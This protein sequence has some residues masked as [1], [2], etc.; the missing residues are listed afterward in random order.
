MRYTAKFSRDA[1]NFGELVGYDT[2][3]LQ[4]SDHLKQPGKPKLPAKTIRIALPAGM[5]V[6]DV[7][8]V[9]AQPVKLAGTYKVYPAQPPRPV[10]DPG[11]EN[12]FVA[13]DS[14][15]YASPEAYPG[16]LAEFIHQ[17]D[18][19]GQG[20]ALVRLY[21]VQYVP[22]EQE[23]TL[24]TS[25]TLLLEGI[26]GY[27]CGDYL[28]A[29]I[30]E[31]G[32]RAYEQAVREMVV[33]PENV[34]LTMSSGS[35]PVSR[36][37][38]P[39]EYE[40]V[41]ITHNDWVDDF[42][43]LADWR[44]KRGI[45]AAIVTTDWIYNDGGYVGSDL[46]KVRSFVEDAHNTWGATYFLLG[47]DT[48]IIPYHERTITVPGYV[49][50]DIPNDTYYA[51][52]DEDWTCE[53]HVARAS[54]RTP[55]AIDTF[56]NKVFTYEKNPPLVDYATTAAFFGFDITECGDED[57]ETYKEDYIRPVFPPAGWTVNTEYDSETGLHKA[58]VI[59]YLDQGHHLVNHHDHCNTDSMGTGWTCHQDLMVTS[60]V[61]AL[62]NGDR[63]SILFAVGCMPCDIP[64]YMSIGEAFVQNPTG[65]GIAF[66]GNSRWGW[67]G[68][69][70]DPNHY[71]LRQDRLLYESLF[72]E[73]LYRL[74][75]C[76]SYLKNGA[77]EGP[78]P[79]NLNQYCFTQLHLL[80]DPGLSVW[81][82]DPQGLT[83][84]HDDTLI[85]GE[86][87]TFP[88]QVHSGGSPVDQAT[89]C[90]WKD[91][92]L[93]EVEETNPSGTASFGFT[94]T[95]TGIMYVTVSGHNYLPYEGQAIVRSE[96]IPTV[97]EWGLV[98]MALILLTAGT[99]VFARTKRPCQPVH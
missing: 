98:V 33:N 83:V 62:T 78:D 21:P 64:A 28:P 89:V 37:V 97:S 7:R 45:R 92:D 71:S 15:I 3:S 91:G 14:Q 35:A 50:H 65:G 19:A 86:Y 10:S 30:S 76:F 34:A 75:Q 11:T 44:T 84:T 18:L 80:S 58:D 93:Y 27:E 43:P 16:K 53:V 94:P 23:L 32:R 70:D 68:P 95:T 47:A 96:P 4:G 67:G 12:D 81:T 46:E 74:G 40:Y 38:G 13:P 77:Y 9:A 2:V 99:L 29:R 55:S 20:I 22:A 52:Y 31:H 54:V 6:T 5:A 79:Y 57:G 61:N 36:G 41:I 17:T 1:L 73:G 25:I 56:I 51:D 48:N 42:Q 85:V 82:E 26:D 72:D 8:I 39:G 90:L 24:Y 66:M 63:Q 59:A 87:T 60:D 69:A 88:V 49:T